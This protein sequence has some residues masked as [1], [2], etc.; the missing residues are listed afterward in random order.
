[1]PRTAQPAIAAHQHEQAA[2]D[3]PVRQVLADKIP[4]EGPDHEDVRMGEVDEAQDAVHHRVPEG[5]QRVDGAKRE[6]VQE[7]LEE[8]RHA[9]G[10]RIS[11]GG[12][13]L[14]ELELA[15]LHHDDDRGLGG[16]AVLV[17]RGRAR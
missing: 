11:L 7:L 1:M 15:V 3:R 2:A 5:D 8:L 4:D 6:T 13:G 12:N 9:A 16:V 14:D 17:H 10:R